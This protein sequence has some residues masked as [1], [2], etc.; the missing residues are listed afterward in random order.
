LLAKIC[1]IVITVNPDRIFEDAIGDNDIYDFSICN[2]PF[3]ENKD[4][5]EKIPKALP[6]RNAFTGNNNELKTIGGERVFVTK[7]IDESI[8]LQD[9]IKIYSTMIGR[10][11]DL[12]HLKK[13]I[14]SRGTT[15]VTW[16][17]FCQGHTTRYKFMKLI[18][19]YI[20]LIL[21]SQF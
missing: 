14:I 12:I 6:P 15:N 9:R 21:K 5:V 13:E 3:F 18:N 2:P 8:K 17:E 20:V 4:D 19:F 16:T 1:D 7:M 11:V 10:K